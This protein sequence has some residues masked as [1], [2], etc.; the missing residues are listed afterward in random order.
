[1]DAEIEM[2]NGYLLTPRVS[3]AMKGL[4]E[5]TYQRNK[6]LFVSGKV[7]TEYPVSKRTFFVCLF[8]NY[9]ISQ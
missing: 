1:M 3:F 2:M 8:L 7:Y 4:E 5:F 6:R 9:F